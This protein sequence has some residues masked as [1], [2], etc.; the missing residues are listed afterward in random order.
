MKPGGFDGWVAFVT[1]GAGGIG[2]TIAKT[3]R[4]L[5]ATVAVGDL[6]KVAHDGTLGVE[7]DVTSE[8]ST[9]DAIST[10]VQESGPPTILVLNAGIFPIEPLESTT[11]DSWE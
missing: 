2:A 6:T 1:G 4:D 11:V 9:H 5:G 3:L 7:S 10:V 8:S